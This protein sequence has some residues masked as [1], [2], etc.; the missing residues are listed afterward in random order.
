MGE[1]ISEPKICFKDVERV[2][3]IELAGNHDADMPIA[4]FV[5]DILSG[6]NNVRESVDT[7]IQKVP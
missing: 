3:I 1:D 5:N 2:T 4:R 6:N 7:L